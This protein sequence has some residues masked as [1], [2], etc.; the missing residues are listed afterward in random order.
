MPIA[1][2]LSS[3]GV[4]SGKGGLSGRATHTPTRSLAPLAAHVELAE[5]A[6]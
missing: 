6:R 1:A 3:R 2:I 5:R 4:P